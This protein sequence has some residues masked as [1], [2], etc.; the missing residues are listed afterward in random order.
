[1][2]LLTPAF[3]FLVI[4]AALVTSGCESY[5]GQ[6]SG[7]SQRDLERQRKLAERQISR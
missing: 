6:G 2:K 5:D 3:L 1:M 4:L 7:F